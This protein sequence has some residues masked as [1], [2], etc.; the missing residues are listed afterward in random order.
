MSHVSANGQ[1]ISDTVTLD[2]RPFSSSAPQIHVE[3][4]VFLM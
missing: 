4:G 1:E 3:K 2:P